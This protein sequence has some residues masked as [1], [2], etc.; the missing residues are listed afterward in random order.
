MEEELQGKHA[1]CVNSLRQF[2]AR[3]TDCGTETSTNIAFS[4]V[5]SS[6]YNHLKPL[7]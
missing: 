1:D 3:L 5:A 2:E 6:F 7:L 4:V